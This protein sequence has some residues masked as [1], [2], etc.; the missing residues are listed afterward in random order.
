MRKLLII[1]GPQGSGNHLWTHIFSDNPQVVGWSDLV[2]NYWAP[3]RSEKFS[4]LWKSPEKFYSIDESEWS[5]DFYITSIS[6]P[7]GRDTNKN[8]AGKK[9]TWAKYDRFI[10]AATASGFEVVVA[11]LGRDQNIL[12]HQQAR[13][14][15]ASTTHFMLDAYDT[16]LYKYNPIFISTELLYL[17][18][19]RYL[20]QVSK[21][22]DFPVA[23]D[24]AKLNHMLDDDCN[25]KYTKPYETQYW[26]DQYRK[27]VSR[28][29]EIMDGRFGSKIGLKTSTWARRPL[30]TMYDELSTDTAIHPEAENYLAEYFTNCTDPSKEAYWRPNYMDGK[31]DNLAEYDTIVGKIKEDNFVLDVG[32]GYNPFKGRI[33]NLV[34]ID[35]YNPAAD[36]VVDILDYTAPLNSFDV[37]IA[38]GATNLYSFKLIM[39]QIEKIVSLVKPGGKIFMRVNPG[40]DEVTSPKMA[41]CHWTVPDIH[42]LTRKYNLTIVDPILLTETK[43]YIFTWQK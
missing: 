40:F 17:Y 25:T 19:K 24:E 37:V 10:D 35:K 4:A 9:V 27:D 30:Y 33:K 2:A 36:Q 41:C 1:T 32:C 8:A 16:L 12:K 31:T 6:C 5:G 18:K 14:K 28:N 23:I 29:G 39:M 20:D 15:H 43:R 7:T 21:L 26:L 38:L 3:H 34:S 11:I 42:F 22:L 13:I